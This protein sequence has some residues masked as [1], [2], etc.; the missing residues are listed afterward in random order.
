MSEGEERRG[1][2]RRQR[3]IRG[4]SC[5]CHR[6]LVDRPNHKRSISNAGYR[7]LCYQVTLASMSCPDKLGMHTINDNAAYGLVKRR[8]CVFRFRPV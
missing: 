5:L 1:E 8:E 7:L 3:C 2:G 6:S 4:K